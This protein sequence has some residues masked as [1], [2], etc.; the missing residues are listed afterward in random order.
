MKKMVSL[1]VLATLLAG[2][3]E[4]TSSQENG[5][6]WV[7]EEQLEPAENIVTD[8]SYLMAPAPKY[9]IGNPYKVDGVQYLPGEDYSYNQVGMA[10]IIPMEL[11]GSKTQ[12]GETVLSTQMIGTSKTLP[13][14]SIVRVTNLENGSSVT[15]RVNSRG[16]FVNSRIMDLSAAAARQIGLTGTANVQV[17]ILE[18]ES[19]AV[20]KAT[21]GEE[22]KVAVAEPAPVVAEPA[23]VAA[24]PAVAEPV[25]VAETTAE[26]AVVAPAGD[27]AV[28]ATAVYS[29]DNAK[30][31]AKELEQYGKVAVVYEG[32]MYKVRIIDLNAEQARK[33][34][35]ALR[36]EKNIAP[37]LLKSGKWINADSI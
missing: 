3:M 34:I 25:V 11:N 16:P 22:E 13:L 15:V 1:A 24:A 27:Y 8:E 6:M 7:S 30:A 21:L 29:E 26:P 20:K 9:Y 32:D 12:D 19:I 33:V 28:Q 35:D 17:H 2:C 37:G 4:T 36:S 10:G 14:P 5:G 31:F 18:Q 23:P